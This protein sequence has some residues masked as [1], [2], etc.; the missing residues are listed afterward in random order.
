M[1]NQAL[2]RG[3]V[4]GAG[5]GIRG[6]LPGGVYTYPRW[7]LAMHGLLP[8]EPAKEGPS[9]FGLEYEAPWIDITN[10]TQYAHLV[11]DLIL[12]N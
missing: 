10:Q 4:R 6:S 1:D 8:M 11:S 7:S 5:L 2:R 12:F 9:V 3:E